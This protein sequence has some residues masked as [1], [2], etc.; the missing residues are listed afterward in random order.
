MNAAHN[1]GKV[2][3]NHIL[4]PPPGSLWYNG[5]FNFVDGLTNEQ[6]TFA[7]GFA[8]I[9]DNFNVTDGGGWDL[10]SVFS[11]DLIRYRCHRRHLGDSERRFLGQWGHARRQR[12]H[13]LAD[14]H[15]DRQ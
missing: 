12:Q 7:P 5:D 1:H 15:S 3:R 2:I 10:T 8:H 13:Q 4:A 14:Y 9:Y 6:D 11:H